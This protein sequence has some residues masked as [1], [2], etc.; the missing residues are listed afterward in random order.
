MRWGGRRP[1]FSNMNSAEVYDPIDNS[2]NPIAPMDIARQGLGVAALGGK[3]YAVGGQGGGSYLNS[4]E[5]YDP[6]DNSWNP[7]A[8]MNVARTKRRCC[9][10]RR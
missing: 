5:V 8:S 3:L 9:S 10:I 4:A 6:I 7:I 1:G 2:W